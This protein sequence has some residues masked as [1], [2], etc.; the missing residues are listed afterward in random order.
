[1]PT[2]R[3]ADGS[4]QAGVRRSMQMS[5]EEAW[6]NWGESQGMARWLGACEEP[7]EEGKES[8]LEDGTRIKAVRVR[9]PKQLRL[10]LEREDWAQP[11]TAQ[12]RILKAARG[13]TVALHLEGLSSVRE[14]SEV[15]ERWTQA[16][17]GHAPAPSRKAREAQAAKSKKITEAARGRARRPRPRA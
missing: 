6:K 12:L 15:I 10:R 14:R 8:A 4:Y 9:P 2:G 5:A 13:V 17:E 1:M 11:R 3:A 16:L 7:L